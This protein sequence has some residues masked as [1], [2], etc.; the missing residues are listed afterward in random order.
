MGEDIEAEYVRRGI[1]CINYTPR[2][3]AGSTTRMEDYIYRNADRIIVISE[4]T[5]GTVPV[6]Q[7]LSPLCILRTAGC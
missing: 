5:M 3:H 7:G 2:R 6:V 1:V 4:C